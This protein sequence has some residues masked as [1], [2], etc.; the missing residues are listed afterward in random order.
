MTPDSSTHQFL[1]LFITSSYTP[2]IFK[3]TRITNHSATLLDNVFTNHPEKVV[4]T[5]ILISDVS[6]HLSPF[7]I[8]GHQ[9]ASTKKESTFTYKRSIHEDGIAKF[10]TL[11]QSL[12]WNYLEDITNVNEKYSA[13]ITN[14]MSIYDECFPMKKINVK[15]YDN[16]QTWFNI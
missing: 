2:T 10:Y 6:D 13:F 1:D 14:F 5:G 4:Q 12:E 11:L 8:L 9:Q 3:P 7:I 16:A 15:K